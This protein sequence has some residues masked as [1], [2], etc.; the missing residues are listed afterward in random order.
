MI[1]T[2]VERYKG[3]PVARLEITLRL[4]LREGEAPRDTRERVR[5]RVETSRVT[6]HHR[7]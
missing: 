7:G 4:P 1:A 6:G 5:V 2:S 3:Q